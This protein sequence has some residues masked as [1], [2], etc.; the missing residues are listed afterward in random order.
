MS[1]FDGLS[2]FKCNVFQFGNLVFIFYLIIKFKYA[3]CLVFS[4]EVI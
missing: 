4:F 3:N 1:L 2:L